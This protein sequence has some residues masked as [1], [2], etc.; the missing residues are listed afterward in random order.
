MSKQQTAVEWLIQEL[1]PSIKLQQKY[2]DELKTKANK[3]F[4]QQVIDFTD[5]YILEC[6][7]CSYNGDPTSL[8]ET[9]DY[10]NETFGE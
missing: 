6:L 3:M 2:I 8:K 9:E 7:T 5:N 4:E 1:R 10:Y